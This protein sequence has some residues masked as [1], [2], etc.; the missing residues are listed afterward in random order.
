MISPPSS[1]LHYIGQLRAVTL[2]TS[3]AHATFALDFGGILSSLRIKKKK[4]GRW[5]E[6]IDAPKSSSAI[7][8][9]K[10]FSSAKLIPFPN[11]VKD[12][13]YTV[14]KSRFF[15]KQNFPSQQHAIHGLVYNKKWNVRKIIAEKEH[16]T[17]I[18][19]L[20]LE[21][22]QSYP[23]KLDVSCKYILSGRKLTCTTTIVNIGKR[24]QKAPIG[25]GWHPYFA[26]KGSFA[27][28]S[29]DPRAIIDVDE[30]MIPTRK[31]LE[32]Q[33]EP[34]HSFLLKYKQKNGFLLQKNVAHAMRTLDTCFVLKKRCTVLQTRD[35][36]LTLKQDHNYPFLQIFTPPNKHSIAIEPM[37]CWPDAFNNKKGLRMLAS[38]E[39]WSGTY[40]ISID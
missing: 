6:I 28:V 15:L 35:F 21:P 34:F 32:F 19:G 24:K 16:I 5:V 33:T 20:I 25:D 3:V 40:D 12:G 14:G 10:W 13:M 18:I 17:L 39:K 23:H 37:S 36:T 38:G 11:R 2:C 27:K 30:R 29:F 4:N 31:A 7:V 22:E 1:K 26:A 9:N 8:A